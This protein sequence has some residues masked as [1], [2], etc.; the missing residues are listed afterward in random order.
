VA[1]FPNKGKGKFQ[2]LRVLANI[3]EGIRHQKAIMKEARRR[4]K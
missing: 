1:Q 2:Y 4:R 3:R